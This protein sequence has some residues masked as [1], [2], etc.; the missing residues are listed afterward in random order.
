MLEP[1]ALEVW[2]YEDRQHLEQEE[3]F[4]QIGGLAT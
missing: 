3:E 1:T 4:E 2:R